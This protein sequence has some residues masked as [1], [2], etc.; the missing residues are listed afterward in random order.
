MMFEYFFLQLPCRMHRLQC[1]RLAVSSTY[2]SHGSRSSPLT[3]H[4][5]QHCKLCDC[6]ELTNK[7]T[8]LQS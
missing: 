6:V 3:D 7:I 8:H 5:P 2:F 4:L 1:R